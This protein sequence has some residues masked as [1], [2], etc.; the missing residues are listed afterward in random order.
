MRV[1]TVNLTLH[2]GMKSM[3]FNKKKDGGGGGGGF[4]GFDSWPPTIK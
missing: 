2:G 1:S 4:Q 3:Q